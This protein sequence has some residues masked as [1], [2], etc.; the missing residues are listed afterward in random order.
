MPLTHVGGRGIRHR[1]GAG[2]R[3]PIGGG[4]RGVSRGPA[5]G[6]P[7]AAGN[8]VSDAER[9]HRGWL[10]RW[11]GFEHNARNSRSSWKITVVDRMSK[12]GPV[13]KL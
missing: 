11:N 2:V 8:G 10:R 3:F 9:N 4:T 12:S 6:W 7:L 1:T 5:L 13:E